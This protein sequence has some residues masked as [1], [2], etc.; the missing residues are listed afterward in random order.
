MALALVSRLGAGHPLVTPGVGHRALIV[1]EIIGG[2]IVL[3]LIVLVIAMRNHGESDWQGWLFSYAFVGFI[4]AIVW[5]I[6][7][8]QILA[9]CGLAAGI[10]FGTMCGL[11]TYNKHQKGK[12]TK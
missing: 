10:I 5:Y 12:P 1:A 9:L 7:G 3:G 6:I 8:Q 4:W 2:I 11:I